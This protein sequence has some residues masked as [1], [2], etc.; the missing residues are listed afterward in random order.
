MFYHKGQI[1]KNQSSNKKNIIVTGA[2]GLLGSEFVRTISAFGENPILIDIDDSNSSRVQGLPKKNLGQIILWWI[3][4]KKI[5][6][7]KF[8][9]R[10]SAK[11]LCCQ[12]W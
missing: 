4:H 7:E 10:L 11:K 1:L 8:K 5:E 2:L 9:E 6:I 3:L 12:G